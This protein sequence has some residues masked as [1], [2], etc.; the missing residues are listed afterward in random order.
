[1]AGLTKQQEVIVGVGLLALLGYFAFKPSETVVVA[2]DKKG[3]DSPPPTIPLTIKDDPEIVKKAK[4]FDAQQQQGAFVAQ[5]VTAFGAQ[6][7]AYCDVR[8]QVQQS[9]RIREREIQGTEKSMLPLADFMRRDLENLLKM[10]RDIE[11][12]YQQGVRSLNLTRQQAEMCRNVIEV[13]IPMDIRNYESFLHDDR[14][15]E[16]DLLAQQLISW[17]QVQNNNLFQIQN[18]ITPGQ[19][20]DYK[21][22]DID[23]PRNTAVIAHMQNTPQTRRGRGGSVYSQRKRPAD[24]PNFNTQTTTITDEDRLKEKHMMAQLALMGRARGDR[25]A[26]LTDPPPPNQLQPS[27]FVYGPADAPGAQRPNISQVKQTTV[28]ANSAFNQADGQSIHLS[29]NSKTE[30]DRI[31][32]KTNDGDPHPSSPLS[33]GSERFARAPYRDIFRGTYCSAGWFLTATPHPGRGSR[34]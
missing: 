11:R 31:L 21:M 5:R 13:V 24:P 22:K 2:P 20:T 6:F 29:G 23:D 27:E 4:A 30:Q 32:D 26:S 33:Y 8:S 18:V 19:D 3:D 12:S 14:D 15:S 9:F 16:N 28:L 1:M 17:T 10:A 25:T 34:E 7:N